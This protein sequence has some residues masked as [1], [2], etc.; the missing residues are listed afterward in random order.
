MAKHSLCAGSGGGE[1]D[2]LC[3]VASREETG[4]VRSASMM[5]GN[6]QQL[7]GRK[8]RAT[9]AVSCCQP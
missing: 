9:F 7:A 8:G 5:A 6:V 1:R 4:D 2:L 3:P